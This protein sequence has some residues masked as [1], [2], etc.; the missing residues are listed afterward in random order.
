MESPRSILCATDLSSGSDRAVLEADAW[1]RRHGASLAFLHVIQDTSRMHVLFPQFAQ[2]AFK[3]LPELTRRTADAVADR[4]VGLTSR[5]RSDFEIRVDLGSPAAVIVAVAE[6]VAADLVVIGAQG[7][8]PSAGSLGA[9]ALRVVQHAHS[10]VLLVREGPAKGPLLVASDLSDSNFPAIS[11][12]SFVARTLGED[13][14]VLHVAEP[15]QAPLPSPEGAGMGLAYS[16][17]AEDLQLLEEAAR[18]RLH[19]A[20]MRQGAEGQC[21]VEQGSPAVHVVS[22]ARRLGA[23]LLVIGTEG[24]TGL[25][26]ILLG[27]TAEQILREATCPV[28]VVRLHAKGGPS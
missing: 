16:L 15:P 19:S 20:M 22:A 3:E 27:S 26:R 9:V 24:R 10:P 23:R 5:A 18:D 17:S 2:K 7:G 6:E 11:A 14:T 8:D 21:L 13:L 28:L 1:A 12:G 4:V 25:R